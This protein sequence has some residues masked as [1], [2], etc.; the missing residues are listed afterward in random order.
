V[1]K[2]SGALLKIESRSKVPEADQRVGGETDEG[3]ADD[4]QDQVARE[5]EQEHREDE[6]VEVGEEAV[7][8]SVRGHVADRVEMDQH[9]DPADDQAHV[10][11]QRVDQDVQL[12]VEPGGARVVVEGIGDLAM[13]DRQ[14]E[15]LHQHPDRGEEGEPDHRRPDPPRGASG[16]HPPREADDQAPGEREGEHEPAVG[17]RAHLGLSP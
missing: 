3:P 11:R 6:E 8:A 17:G 10:D 15:D 14:V 13:V 16:E 4:Q 1:W 7:E 9:R 2:V 12:D 5:D